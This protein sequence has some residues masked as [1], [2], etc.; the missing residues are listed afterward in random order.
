[1]YNEMVLCSIANPE[2]KTWVTLLKD[3]LFRYGLGHYW[4]NQDFINPAIYCNA[5]QQRVYDVFLQEWQAEVDMNSNFRL[6][7]CVIVTFRF[8]NYLSMYNMSFRIA[9]TK[10]RLSSHLFYVERGRWGRKKIEHVNRQCPLC[11]TIEDEY[12]CV[13]ECP[14]YI[15]ERKGCVP[16][17]M[18]KRP[19]LP[20]II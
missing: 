13:V 4:E 6:Y 19:I 9:I 5:F 14:R 15:E 2:I 1:M 18:R 16:E 3:M 10:I 12:H 7:K 17:V 20:P 11:K 8:E